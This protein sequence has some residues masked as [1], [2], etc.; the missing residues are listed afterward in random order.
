MIHAYKLNGY[1]IILDVGSGA[2]H[3]VDELAYEAICLYD[4]KGRDASYEMIINKHKEMD[5]SEIDE[6]F[7]DIDELVGH[8][9]LF[10]ADGLSETAI[11]KREEQLESEGIEVGKAYKALCMN[12][13]HSCNMLCEYCFAG[14]GEYGGKESLMPLEIGKKAID[15]LIAN[16]NERRNLDVDFFGGEPLI[17]WNTVKEIVL[18]AREKEKDT[19]KRFRFTL[20]T[21]GLLIDDDIIDFTNKHMYNVVLS[22][23]GRRETHDGKRKYP[24]GEGTYA[25]VLP[26]IRRLV[27]SRNGKGYYIRGTFTRD[28]RDFL[29]DILHIADMGF[30]EIS[31]EP[32]VTKKDDTEGFVIDDLPILFDQYENLAIQM[33]NREREG[34][35][36]SFYH[37]MLDL[38]NGPCL[39]KRIAG[40]GV[41]TEYL[42]VTPNGELYPCHQ[43]VGNEQFLMG[44]VIYG[45]T[46]VALYNKFLHTGI[47]SRSD[48]ESC[49]ARF[50]CSGGCSAN[51]WNSSGDINGIYEFG[52][53][54]FKKRIECAIMIKV[55][56]SATA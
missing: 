30:S 11:T 22:L 54:L 4:N 20:T 53:E 16:S 44:D 35:G 43:F 39:H 17:N 13:S 18:Y 9:K 2:I 40:C 55:A 3:W 14:K 36:F 7:I 56:E 31:L 42:A 29:D 1:N 6:L 37:F 15:Y 23:D 28:N 27:E 52:C 51:A 41:G 33:I 49:W 12:V 21:N 19:E 46:N 47:H 48:C 26:N 38:V 50:Y 32:I 24:N 8:Q 25:V 10:A 34:R 5:R 45:I